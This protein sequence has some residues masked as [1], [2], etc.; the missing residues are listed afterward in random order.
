MLEHIQCIV[1][2]I[3]GKQIHKQFCQYNQLLVFL[4]GKSLFILPVEALI[5]VVIKWFVLVFFD[6]LVTLL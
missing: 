3:E 4:D 5:L 1:K 2:V 6:R